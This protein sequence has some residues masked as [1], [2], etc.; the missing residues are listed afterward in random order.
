MWPTMH[1]TTVIS[2]VLAQIIALGVFGIKESSVASG[3][4][5][6]LVILTL[7]F[8]EY[9]RQRFHPMFKSF[10]AQVGTSFFPGREGGGVGGVQ[11]TS[12]IVIDTSLSGWICR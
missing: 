9:C 7:L 2:L 6:V 11:S 5:I 1:N 8:N 10:S 12:S 4:T 3:F